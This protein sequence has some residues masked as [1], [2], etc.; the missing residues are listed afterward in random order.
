MDHSSVL[1]LILIVLLLA[2][3]AAGAVGRRN[4]ADRR[5]A[6]VERKLDAVLAH[7]GVELPEPGMDRVHALLAEGKRIEAIK[8]YRECTDADLR[9]AK[10]AVDRLAAGS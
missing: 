8:A 7:L 1:M 4:R 5:V 3:A 9:E 10:E 2:T 6:R